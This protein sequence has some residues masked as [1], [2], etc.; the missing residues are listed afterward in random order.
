MLTIQSSAIDVYG[1]QLD[2]NHDGVPGGD[3]ELSFSTGAQDMAPP[4]VEDVYPSNVAQNV[5][6]QPIIS[7]VF[8][9][10]VGPD[11][12]VDD[13]FYIERF[14]D[15]SV[16][17]GVTEHYDVNEHSILNFFP[18]QKLEAD[19]TYV[20]RLL[21]GLSDEFNNETTT[22][23]SYS[24]RTGTMDIEIENIDSFESS[25]LTNWWDPQMSGSTTGIIADNTNMSINSDIVNHLTNSSKSMQMNYAWN[26]N[27][28]SWL[29][30]EYLSGGAPRNVQFTDGYTLQLYV[31]GD[32]GGT[33]LRF[34][35]DDHLPATSASYHEVSPW[36]VI[37]WYGWRLISW[38]MS[39]DGTGTWLGDGN[40]D[41][42]LRIDSIQLTRSED[43]VQSG[44]LIFDDLRIIN[45]VSL[46]T[47][48]N[49]YLANK[50][51]LFPGY[52]NP[53]NSST[54]ISYEIGERSFVKLEIFNIYGR[55]VKTIV[56]RTQN[57]GHYSVSWHGK[58][59]HD[60]D[61]SSG[62]YLYRLS[63]DK[64]VLTGKVTLIK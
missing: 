51:Q 48:E 11:S 32:G 27:S 31:F 21:P 19:E 13:L 60:S 44:T 36:F 4:V 59:K 23:N 56:N 25:V 12:L 46:G 24:F 22:T 54:M 33:K 45:H 3:Y 2:G 53:F 10:A 38:N 20:T 7:V 14:L 8:D 1:H 30:R 52:P 50:Y 40:L 34:C 47:N 28:S 17:P 42:T 55:F 49:N 63:A 41:G 43:S 9:E 61:V 62:T 39:T 64:N 26:M 15:H 37:D 35:V 16:V 29:I 58:D 6:L 57:E 18:Y 5:E